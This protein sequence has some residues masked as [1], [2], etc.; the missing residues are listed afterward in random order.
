V[1]VGA[2]FKYA[3]ADQNKNIV[4]AERLQF[5]VNL[6]NFPDGPGH[7]SNKPAFPY[8]NYLGPDQ[9]FFNVQPDIAKNNPLLLQPQFQQIAP[10]AWSGYVW[11]PKGHEV[12]DWPGIPGENVL[13]PLSSFPNHGVLYVGQNFAHAGTDDPPA[14]FDYRLYDPSYG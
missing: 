6:W 10:H 9:N 3:N 8:A 14:S 4:L 2:D 13:N 11:D 12:D 5:L 1:Q 7:I